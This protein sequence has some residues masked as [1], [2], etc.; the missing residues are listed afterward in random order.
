MILYNLGELKLRRGDIESPEYFSRSQSL[1]SKVADYEQAI[2]SSLGAARWFIG[3]EDHDEAE[4][5][6]RQ[7]SKF[8][9]LGAS[10]EH[11][12]SLKSAQASVAYTRGSYTAAYRL[13]R[14]ALALTRKPEFAAFALDALARAGLRDKFLDE[15][16]KEL[17]RWTEPEAQSKF[18]EGLLRSVHAW[19]RSELRV[20]SR[21]L[22]CAQ[23]LSGNGAVGTSRRSGTSRQYVRAL[24]VA[25]ACVMTFDELVEAHGAEFDTAFREELISI[26]H[27]E[28]SVSAVLELMA[29]LRSFDQKADEAEI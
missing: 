29:V 1:A 13:W 20:A 18:A 15:L 21:A 10:P 17:D 16:D 3:S 9:E 22:A 19:S 25:R 14:G 7:A 4:R 6:I 24:A 11:H 12:A 8:A 28:E 26:I 23:V 5:W 27:D 2:D